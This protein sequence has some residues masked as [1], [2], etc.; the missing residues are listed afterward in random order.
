MMLM[1]EKA[2]AHQL[3]AEVRILWASWEGDPREFA[4]VLTTY[5]MKAKRAAAI[6]AHASSRDAPEGFEATYREM[7]ADLG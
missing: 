4:G 3:E 5:A 7:E 6:V 2:H 1:F